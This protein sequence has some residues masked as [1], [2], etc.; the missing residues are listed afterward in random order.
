MSP[1]SM[2]AKQDEQ[3]EAGARFRLVVMVDARQFRRQGIAAAVFVLT[4]RIGGFL[5]L[6]QFG[7]D[8]C[9]IFIAGFDK[10]IALFRRQRFALAAEVDAL[11]V[12]QF[13]GKLLDLQFAPLEFGVALGELALQGRDLRQGLFLLCEI[14]AIPCRCKAQVHEANYALKEA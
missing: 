3:E 7:D 10:Q 6:F 1:T 12:R 8:G 4:W 11:V 2:C 14:D 9:A 5:V 13:E